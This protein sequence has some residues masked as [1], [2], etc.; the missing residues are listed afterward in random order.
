MSNKKSANVEKKRA[1][2][3]NFINLTGSD[4]FSKSN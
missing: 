4:I 2:Y 3:Q 1:N